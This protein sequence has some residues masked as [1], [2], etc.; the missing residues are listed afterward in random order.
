MSQLGVQFHPQALSRGVQEKP[1]RIFQTLRAI[2][3]TKNERRQAGIPHQD[4]R[5]LSSPAWFSSPRGTTEIKKIRREMT[6]LR[7]N[8]HGIARAIENLRGLRLSLVPCAD[9]RKCLLPGVCS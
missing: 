7:R 8:S 1:V 4:T 2:S 3:M 5:N 6:R 9:S